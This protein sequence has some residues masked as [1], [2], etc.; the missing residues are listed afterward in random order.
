MAQ[1]KG[2]H[3]YARLDE[4][5][6]HVSLTR[7]EAALL[8]DMNRDDYKV[9]VTITPVPAVPAMTSSQEASSQTDALMKHADFMILMFHWHVKS[10]HAEDADQ[11]CEQPN[12]CAGTALIADNPGWR[13]M[14]L[15]ELKAWSMSRRRGQ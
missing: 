2:I 3:I 14:G 5:N 6:L 11:E 12:G 8:R 15:E 10:C 7:E 13:D 1:V 4:A 9:E